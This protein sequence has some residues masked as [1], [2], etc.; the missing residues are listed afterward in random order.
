MIKKLPAGGGDGRGLFRGRERLDP[1]FSYDVAEIDIDHVKYYFKYSCICVQP[2]V[3][4]EYISE[5]A[6]M[7]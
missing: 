6:H 7:S 5:S 1:A 2:H 3:I 4:D